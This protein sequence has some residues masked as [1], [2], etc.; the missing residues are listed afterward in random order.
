LPIYRAA[1]N[2]LIQTDKIYDKFQRDRRHTIWQQIC[3]DAGKLPYLVCIANDFPRKREEAIMIML[4]LVSVIQSKL[5]VCKI[6]E[7]ISIDDY[8]AFAKPISSIER[9][10]N[11]WLNQTR[12]AG[13][14]NDSVESAYSYKGGSTLA[15]Q[16]MDELRTS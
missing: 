9:Q 11:G 16:M 7:Y 4:G 12:N 15:D 14:D 8:L 3:N 13:V 5:E 6:R 10:A 2:M 1:M